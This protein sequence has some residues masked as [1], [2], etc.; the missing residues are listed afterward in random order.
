MGAAHPTRREN[1]MKAQQLINLSKFIEETGG[2]PEF[3]RMNEKLERGEKLQ[4]DALEKR[5]L[6]GRKAKRSLNKQ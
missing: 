3:V 1:V 2:F 6:R 5:V 4:R